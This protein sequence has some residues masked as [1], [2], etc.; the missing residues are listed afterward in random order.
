MNMPEKDFKPISDKELRKLRGDGYCS[1]CS[2]CGGCT[3][4]HFH[5]TKCGCNLKSFGQ[6]GNSQP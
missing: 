5:C 4:G 6:K 2:S 1:L 3:K